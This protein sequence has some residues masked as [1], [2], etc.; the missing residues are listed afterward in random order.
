MIF[1]YMTRT[2]LKPYC[3][4]LS[5]LGLSLTLFCLS[6]VPS[7]ICVTPLLLPFFLTNLVVLT[8]FFIHFPLHLPCICIVSPTVNASRSPLSV[9]MEKHGK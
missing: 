8:Q 2:L 7:I 5:V 6:I 3:L 9:I 1:N 4:L